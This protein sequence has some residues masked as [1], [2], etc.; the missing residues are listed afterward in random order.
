MARSSRVAL[1]A[2]AAVS[3]IVATGAWWMGAFHDAGGT[4][5]KP[6]GFTGLRGTVVRFA[7]VDEG[8]ALLGADDDWV[9]QTSELQRSVLMN[10]EPPTPLDV[11]RAFQAEAVQAWEPAAQARWQRA[12][13]SIAPALDRLALPWPTELLLVQTGGR[14]SANQ[15][16]TRANAIVLPRQFEQQ[17]YSD[18][19]VLAH[20]LWHVVS[21]GHPELATKLYALIGYEP[22]AE[23]QWP[24]R[25]QAIRT[26]NQDA[27][28]NRHAM[29]VTLH[30]R[31]TMLMPV[32]VM[33]LEAGEPA[34]GQSLLDLME[35]RLLEVLP[36][37]GGVPTTAVMHDGDPVWHTIDDAP[38]FVER[39]GGNTDYMQHPDETVADNLMFLVSGRPVKNPELLRRIEALLRARP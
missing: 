1:I 37:A 38:E 20:E 3:L 31:D 23:L 10:R 22:V 7:G 36:G 21:R 28:R 2:L 14:E 33:A 30:G 15:P 11:F 16:H 39:L 34:G 8:R 6:A 17:G 4:L 12:L 25:W 9:G 5:A 13:E 26:A 35:L 24:P 18:A 19:E 27:P 32:V 29:H